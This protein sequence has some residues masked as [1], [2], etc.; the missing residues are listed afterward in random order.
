MTLLLEKISLFFFFNLFSFCLSL[1][2]TQSKWIP[3]FY[4]FCSPSGK[5]TSGKVNSQDLENKQK[6]QCTSV[7]RMKNADFTK[8]VLLGCQL[9]AVNEV[10]EGQEFF[11]LQE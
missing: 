4:I 2:C 5:I 8:N 10:Y 7:V 3:F 9:P 6:Y 11:S 1:N